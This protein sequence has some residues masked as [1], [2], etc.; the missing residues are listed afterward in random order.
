MQ[1]LIEFI[2]GLDRGV[3]GQQGEYS[4][5]F[6]PVWPLQQYIS[7]SAW[8]ILLIA[9]VA[10]CVWGIYRRESGSLKFRLFAGTLRLAL[11]LLVVAILNR[12]LLSLTQT[13]EERSVLAVL[14]DDSMSMRVA[15]APGETPGEPVTRLAAAKQLFTKNSGALLRELRAKH[16]LRLFRFSG[17]ASQLATLSAEEQIPGVL[18][19]LERIEPQ[20]QSTR[21]QSSIAQVAQQLAGQRVAG[22]VVLTDGREMPAQANADTAAHP[23]G[24]RLFP[25]P[26]GGESRV[27]NVS[28]RSVA[29]Q[30]VVFK[31]DLV[32]V[33]AKIAVTGA[34]APQDVNIALLRDDKGPVL[35]ADGREVTATVRVTGDGTYDTD[36][37]FAAT[38]AGNV[39]LTITAAKL[40][41]E[42]TDDDNSRAFQITVLDAQVNL[43]YVEGYPRWEFRYLKTQMMRETSVQ[44]STLLT[45]ADPDYLQ[46]GDRPIRYFPNTMDQLM[47]YDV[48]IV[49]DVD[50]RQFTDA[51]LQL[52]RDF[53][54]KKGGGFGMIAGPRY[55]PHAWR[56][57]AIEQILPVDISATRAEEGAVEPFRPALTA[58][59]VESPMFRFF[60]AREAN[61]RYIRE[62]LPPLYW[63]ARGVSVRPAVAE[64]YAEHPSI[65]GPDGRRAPLLVVGRPGAG[66]SLFSAIDDSW[67]WRYYTGESIFDTYWVQQIRYLARGR[68]VGQR[69]LSFASVQ[70]VYEL[71]EQVQ[72]E[73]RI[74]DDAVAAQ[75][76]DAVGVD[77]LDAT[78]KRIASETLQRAG[79]RKD[80]FR[81][82]LPAAEVGRYVARLPSVAAGIDAAQATFDVIAPRLELSDPSPARS[83]L[84][85]YAANTD[86][87]V[88]ELGNATSELLAIP[89]AARIV[90][91]QTNWRMWSSPLLLGLL[92]FLLTL[93]WLAR[94][95]AG[96]I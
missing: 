43:L 26:L 59:G 3:L 25:V 14:L 20:G 75:L 88:I 84:S 55:S 96:L 23:A 36:M 91:V 74:I 89:S 93:E 50:P 28:I 62:L 40:P 24:I 56:G 67:R 4:L 15:D 22:L 33:R 35:G 10:L 7:A 1:R 9:G 61:D 53:V 46:E 86:G 82:L 39:A 38:D 72:L 83:V 76:P 45:S 95:V 69:R 48:V 47:E 68:K 31:G 13:R 5:T 58:E 90:P 87:K 66:R 49:G 32:S 78:G 2:L 77:L 51:Q 85:Q 12:P 81:L 44:I 16:E 71:G 70:P 79:S 64:V 94:K 80:L 73:L 29:A 34:D 60:A 41:G 19:E 57:T 54:T 17:S 37:V 65:T 30:D 52:L 18:Q 92:M 27:K 11:L 42:I 63:F 6:D 8:N 21:L